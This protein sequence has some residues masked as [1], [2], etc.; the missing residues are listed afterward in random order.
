MSS[1]TPEQ[2][3]QEQQELAA[4]KRKQYREDKS[5]VRKQARFDE[6]TP[7]PN[8]STALPKRNIIVNVLIQIHFLIID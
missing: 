7:E 6:T 8:T 2:S 1:N 5:H 4:S 3:Q